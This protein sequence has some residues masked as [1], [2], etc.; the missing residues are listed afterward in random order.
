M[1]PSC[2]HFFEQDSDSHGHWT[3]T[4]TP[5]K[6]GVGADETILKAD[7][8]TI[9]EDCIGKMPPKIAPVFIARFI[10]EENSEKI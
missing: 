6:W 9:L 1:T 4:N 10:D 7:F 2:N 3:K 5:E 8:Y